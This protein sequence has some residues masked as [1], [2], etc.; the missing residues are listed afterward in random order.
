MQKEADQYQQV[1]IRECN[2]SSPSFRRVENKLLFSTA[3]TASL[4]GRRT[5]LLMPCVKSLTKCGAVADQQPLQLCWYRVL[6]SRSIWRS[7]HRSARC[8]SGIPLLYFLRDTL[9][10]SVLRIGSISLPSSHC[11]RVVW[12]FC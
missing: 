12:R 10:L 1:W 11:S 5:P 3:T 9:P 8:P 2:R 7:S 4:N 6:S